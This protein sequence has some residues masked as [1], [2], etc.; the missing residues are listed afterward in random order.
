MLWT[1]APIASSG[2][3]HW[4]LCY[5]GSSDAYNFRSSCLDKGPTVTVAKESTKNGIYGGYT[6]LPWSA[7]PGS[8]QS[9]DKSDSTIFTFRLTDRVNGTTNEFKQCFDDTATPGQLMLDYD[10]LGPCFGNRAFCLSGSDVFFNDEYA[11]MQVGCATSD[12]VVET[13]PYQRFEV[14]YLA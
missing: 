1:S 14:Y 3:K 4:T 5:A 9:Y 11:D 8:E 12:R 13:K 7:L 10:G 6:P 2:N